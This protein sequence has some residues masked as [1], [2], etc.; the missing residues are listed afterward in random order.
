[1]LKCLLTPASLRTSSNNTTRLAVLRL[2]TSSNM[3]KVA[4]HQGRRHTLN[5][6]QLQ[7][8]NSTL[9][10]ISPLAWLHQ[11][12]RASSLLLSRHLLPHRHSKRIKHIRTRRNNKLENSIKVHTGTPRN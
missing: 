12:P 5:L 10:G 11:S 3:R 7:A 2:V 8:S 1:M 6:G 9:R 4:L